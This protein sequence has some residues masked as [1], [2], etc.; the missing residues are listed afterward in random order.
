MA[1]FLNTTVLSADIMSDP[2]IA[3]GSGFRVISNR[4]TGTFAAADRLNIEPGNTAVF[5]LSAKGKNSNN[6]DVL[7]FLDKLGAVAEQPVAQV[8]LNSDDVVSSKKHHTGLPYFTYTLQSPEGTLVRHKHRHPFRPA[9]FTYTFQGDTTIT[10]NFSGVDIYLK[11]THAEHNDS[12]ADVTVKYSLGDPAASQSD[13][14]GPI[15]F[16]SLSSDQNLQ[17]GPEFLRRKAVGII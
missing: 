8:L 7:L 1:T 14:N 5:E 12:G 2:S 13:T 3:E 16:P 15:V 9:T 4:V 17:V 11:T 10:T 6:E